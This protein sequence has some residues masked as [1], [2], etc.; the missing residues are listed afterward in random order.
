MK[1]HIGLHALIWALAVSL[2]IRAQGLPRDTVNKIKSAAVYIR[3][4]RTFS[5]SG[6]DIVTSGSGFFVDD[7]GHVVTNYHVVEPTVTI[8]DLAFP[9]PVEKIEIY[10]NSGSKR[11]KIYEGAILHADK[12]NDLAILGTD[13]TQ[14]PYLRLGGEQELFET[15]PVWIFG[16]PFG[17]V[18]SVLQQGPEI[19]VSRGTVSALRHDDRGALTSIQIDATINPGNSGGPVID[20]NGSVAGIM[21]KIMDESRL[22]FAVPSVFLQSLL[23]QASAA[24][25]D[26]ASL[27]VLSTMHQA[28]LYIDGR[29]VGATPVENLTVSPGW[30][31]VSLAKRGYESWMTERSFSGGEV[32]SVDLRPY[33]NMLL[34]THPTT[35][36]V[37]ARDCIRMSDAMNGGDNGH[38]PATLREQFDSPE[39]FMAWE[40]RSGKESK[41]TWFLRDG[42]VHQHEDDEDLHMLV[43]GDT[44]WREYTA[45][46]AVSM[47]E[48]HKDN[49][50][51]LIFHENADGFYLLR[52]HQG[53]NEAQLAYHTTHPYG[54]FVIRKQKL[55]ADIRTGSHTIAV[56]V[57]HDTIIGYVDDQCVFAAP[58][59]HSRG[60]RVGLYSVDGKASFDSL[61]VTAAHDGNGATRAPAANAPDAAR[62]LLSFWFLDD[63]DLQSTWWR[64]YVKGRG[65]PAPWQFSDGGCAQTMRDS[66]TRISEFMKYR[67]ADFSMDVLISI[68]KGDDDA[69]LGLVFR[70]SGDE[71]CKIEFSKQTNTAQVFRIRR[72]RKELLREGELPVDFFNSTDRILLSV[73]KHTMFLRTSEK[74]LVQFRDRRLPLLAGRVAF[75][76]AN[77]RTILHQMTIS[78]E[79]LME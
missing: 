59:R 56:T 8:M 71:S 63:F 25:A 27:T 29:R 17:D 46:T 55:G 58:A 70:N 48:S 15:T 35:S 21:R 67:F 2:S 24:M 32:L 72:G 37:S 68:G 75:E 49:R 6:E 4:T 7:K 54:W 45:R 52:I 30:R 16:F 62:D 74:V 64:Q 79:F 34:E 51:G 39:R 26:S 78:S 69:L 43:L 12:E 14:T 50:A 20:Q 42:R 33:D 5:L 31:V 57:H 47:R 23:R 38:A 66:L 77:M 13:A 22:T 1:S 73:R 44:S 65:E 76:T 53:L 36:W 10:R 18:F 41:R 9:A 3:V 40:Q 19:T 28:N 60:G 11:H 61:V